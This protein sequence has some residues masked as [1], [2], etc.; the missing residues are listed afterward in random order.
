MNKEFTDRVEYLCYFGFG[1]LQDMG[2]GNVIP[3]A[4]ESIVNEIRNS[5]IEIL[6][7]NFEDKEPEPH[8]YWRNVDVNNAKSILQDCSDIDNIRVPYLEAH[9]G[10]FVLVFQDKYHYGLSPLSEVESL[11]LINVLP[12]KDSWAFV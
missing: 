4:Y 8:Y 6:I 11:R 5:K 9:I 3:T 12:K 1:S 2:L 7:F 10:R